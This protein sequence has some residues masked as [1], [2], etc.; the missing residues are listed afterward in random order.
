MY[1]QPREKCLFTRFDT[2]LRFDEQAAVIYPVAFVDI[3]GFVV[4]NSSSRVC[5]SASCSTYGIIGL[6]CRSNAVPL[7]ALDGKTSHHAGKV[8]EVKHTP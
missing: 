5:F 7:C 3:K 2:T 8:R 6:F 4:I 1:I